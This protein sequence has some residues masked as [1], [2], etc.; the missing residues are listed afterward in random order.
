MKRSGGSYSNRNPG[1]G[2][3]KSGRTEVPRTSLLTRTHGGHYSGRRSS[4]FNGFGLG[5]GQYL[6]VYCTHLSEAGAERRAT[7]TLASIRKHSQQELRKCTAETPVAT[8]SGELHFDIYSC[9][10][11]AGLLLGYHHG[12]IGRPIGYRQ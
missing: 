5:L 6:Q 8:L 7:A 2:T 11:G 1:Y 9:L 12:F 10:L 4:S 3:Y